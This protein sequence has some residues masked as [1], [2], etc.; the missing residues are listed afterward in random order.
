VLLKA[1]CALV[2]YA[3]LE[4]AVFHT[5]LYDSIVE[6]EST[7]GNMEL[8]LYNELARPVFE[9]HQVLAIGDSRIGFL[10]RIANETGRERGY[11]FGTIALG[12]TT[13]RTWYYALRAVD[14][15]ARGYSAILIE[16]SDYDEPE[17]YDY[18]D[19]RDLDLHYVACRI[20]LPDLIDF[21]SSF[22]TPGMKWQ[23]FRAIA[24]KGYVFRKDFEEFIKAPLARLEKVRRYKRESAGWYYGFNG[25]DFSL[26]GI[27]IDWKTKAI[28][29]PPGLSPKQQKSVRDI[30]FP[31]RPERNGRMRAYLQRWYGKILEH[32]KGSPTKLIFLRVPRGPVSRP[33]AEPYA[34]S[35]VRSLAG[36]PGVI[37]MPENRFDE[38]ERGE[39]FGDA[40]HMNGPGMKAFSKMLA[41]DAIRL[42]EGGK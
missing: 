16:S 25:E 21:S 38:L 9:P 29:Y 37:V 33:S 4:G 17:Q 41:E 42:V 7:T 26:A 18:L 6:P 39:F 40:M 30:T 23:A 22:V 13:P 15:T 8:V 2:A 12:G 11:G 28:T 34:G 10:P 20:G 14:P 36:R 24:L 19:N 32:Y 31:D 27:A 35:L 3:A 1:A 5:H